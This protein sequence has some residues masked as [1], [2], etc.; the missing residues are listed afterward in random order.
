MF[1]TGI[2]AL[3]VRA[4]KSMGGLSTI[5]PSIRRLVATLV[6]LSIFSFFSHG[7]FARSNTNETS[8]EFD[9]YVLAL[10]WSPSYCASKG[11]N[12][13]PMQCN[14]AKP[15]GFIVHGLWPQYERGYPDFCQSQFGARIDRR[16]ADA[17]LDIIPSRGLIYHQWKKHG[18][19]SGL[20]P[21][22]YF[23]LT[24][25]AFEKI[26]I[27]PVFKS[28]GSSGSVDPQSVEK[29]FRLANPGLRD[30][31]MAV[32]CERGKL[33]EVRICFDKNLNFRSCRY[34]D[35]GGC[36]AKR[37]DVLAPAR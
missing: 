12:A 36:S 25:Q 8:G 27:P 23:D 31:A 35:R 29:A 34:V 15:F 24:R 33:T 5:A 32:R 2:A 14:R 21:K 37:I 19:C 1:M 18:S 4:N 9:Y 13:D 16:L 3:F 6:A 20:S 22:T 26:R 17:M 10:S 7:A 11:K 28:M 30:N